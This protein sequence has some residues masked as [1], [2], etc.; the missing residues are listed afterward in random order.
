MLFGVLAIA[1]AGSQLLDL[2]TAQGLSS[3]EPRGAFAEGNPLLAPITDPVIRA[4]VGVALKVALVVFVLFVAKLQRR[5]AIGSA[6]LLL[7]IMAG[8]FGTWSNAN[9]WW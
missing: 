2:V 6:I 9:P 8:L 3:T 4:Y 1:F 5:R 7:G